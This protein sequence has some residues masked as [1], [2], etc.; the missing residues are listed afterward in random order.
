MEK[1]VQMSKDDDIDEIRRKKAQ[2]LLKSLDDMGDEERKNAMEFLP[3]GYRINNVTGFIEILQN[4]KNVVAITSDV[5]FGEMITDLLNR[6][7]LYGEAT[8]GLTDD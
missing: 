1:V 6:A 2:E 5:Q 7:H 4:E 8:E 3:W